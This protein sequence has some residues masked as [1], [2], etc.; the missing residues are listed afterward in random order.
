MDSRDEIPADISKRAGLLRQL[1]NPSDVIAS[2]RVL[3]G[4]M[5]KA[6]GMDPAWNALAS[7]LDTLIPA[8]IARVLEQLAMMQRNRREYLA[9]VKAGRD[10]PPL[11]L[12]SGIAAS[13]LEEVLRATGKRIDPHLGPMIE[14]LGTLDRD[15]DERLM[16][17]LENAGPAVSAA[18]PKLLGALRRRG[19][20]S[21]PSH[22]ARALANASR[23]D[24]HIVPTLRDMLA[25]GDEDRRVSAMEVLG[26]IGPG[27]A[28]AEGD[29]LA[30]RQGSE[31]ERCGMIH[32]LA[33]L[34][35]ASLATLEAFDAAMRD[36]SGYVRRCGAHALGVLT[37]EPAR[38]VPLL[39]DACDWP[40]PLHDEDLPEAAVGAL[41]RYGPRA[42]EALPRLRRF[43][44]G[45]IQV[46]TVRADLVRDAIACISSDMTTISQPTLL[47]VRTEP[48]ADEE[49]LFAVRIQG[50][51]CYIDRL[52]RIVIRS[53]Y[54]SGE[55]FHEGRAIVFDE[56]GQTF[57]IDRRGHEV[58]RIDWDE[59]RPNSEGLAAVRKDRKWGFVDRDGRVVI[60]PQ[61]DSVTSFREGLA[62]FELG[63]EDVNLGSGLTWSRSG[64]CGFLDRSGNVV[65]PANWVHVRPFREGRAVVCTGGT[66]KAGR[67]GGNVQ[68]LSDRKYGYIDRTGRLVI[69]GAYDLADSFSDGLAVVQVGDGFCRARY[70]YID[71]GGETV[72]PLK[73]TWASAFRDGLAVVHRR[74][75]RWRGTSLVINRQGET[76]R[77]L[78]YRCV[79]PIS[80]GL[81]ATWS[82][83]A[84]GFVDIEGRWVVEPQFDQVDPFEHGLAEV[85]RGDWYGLIDRSGRFVWGPTT[86]GSLNR[87]IESEWAS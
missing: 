83:E 35:T 5:E 68:V 53:Q 63:R 71:R 12:D 44:E 57:V 30:L 80:E 49:P 17:V 37:P 60:E 27:A 65:I 75:K 52:G 87:T 1:A 4:T 46:R 38:F 86:E 9:A 50:Q 48:V 66:W 55:P 59:I 85:Q 34:G 84:Y 74:G 56:D 54:A 26:T 40:E 6:D 15:S 70:G 67:L 24:P 29:L 79:G 58:F 64:P 14:Q 72:I 36:P 81:L 77:E 28:S 22:L 41:A 7:D 23:Y 11:D 8:W 73:F 13:V 76:V 62:G 61:Y 2:A 45:P 25:S 78:P 82:G 51:A 19:I 42:A 3:F 31:R 21:W 18:V 39:V 33:R 43:L 16:A 20:T 10:S 47:E 69:A 32:T